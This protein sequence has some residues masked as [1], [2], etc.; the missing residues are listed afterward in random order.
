M[1]N[2]F[3]SIAAIALAAMLAGCGGGSEEEATTGGAPQLADNG[4]P[5]A[6]IPDTGPVTTPMADR[7]VPPEALPMTVVDLDEANMRAAPCRW[8]RTGESES[9]FV[10]HRESGVVKVEGS[11]VRLLP[12]PYTPEATARDWEGGG[13]VVTLSRDP[14]QPDAGSRASGE[15]PAMMRIATENG[16]VSDLGPGTITCSG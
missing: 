8:A 16:G 9:R 5:I 3:G 14:A 6:A 13:L 15:W 11:F 4:M 7:P 10:F 1:T 2:R 12:Q